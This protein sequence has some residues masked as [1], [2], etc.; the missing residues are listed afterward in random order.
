MLNVKKSHL[1]KDD[2]IRDAEKGYTFGVLTV[3]LTTTV[4]YKAGVAFKTNAKNR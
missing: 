2:M 4:F 3:L 1:L